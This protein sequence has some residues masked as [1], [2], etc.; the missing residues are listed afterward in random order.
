M[1]ASSADQ[2]AEWWFQGTKASLQ[3]LT[4]TIFPKFLL[5]RKK[6]VHQGGARSQ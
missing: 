6:I 1:K 5:F 2:V 3:R 4:H